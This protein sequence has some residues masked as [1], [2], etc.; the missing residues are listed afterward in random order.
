MTA[1]EGRAG[2]A[3]RFT[4]RCPV[5]PVTRLL[6]R[7]PPRARLVAAVVCLLA[8]AAGLI[9]PSGLLAARGYLARQAE[10]QAR[11]Y[12]RFLASRPF[13]VT[14]VFRFSPGGFA[15]RGPGGDL[16]RIEV[17][18]PDGRPV[19]STGPGR[20]PAL[21][22]A[23]TD[24]GGGSRA[25]AGSK[26][27]GGSWLVIA[28]PVRWRARRIPFD[29]DASAFAVRVTGRA[30][31]QPGQAGTLLVGLDLTRAESGLGTLTRVVLAVCAAVI[32]AAGFLT[33]AASRAVLARAARLAGPAPGRAAAGPAEQ[34]ARRLAG[35]AGDAG[36]P[37]SV[38]RGSAEYYRQQRPLGAREAGRLLQ[39]VAEEAARLDAII[40]GLAAAARPDPPGPHQPPDQ[41][42]PPRQHQPAQHQPPVQDLP[43]AQRDR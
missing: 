28:E 38:I 16:Y 37:L 22:R 26:A 19:V 7:V 9:V 13:T 42:R 12:V 31:H 5:R 8:A 24:P 4:G 29:Y 11:A 3:A 43:P 34:L 33:A 40:D 10:Q 27:R 39:R 20:W 41:A 18:G 25:R 30:L 36:R 14:P 1:D 23:V 17:L 21:P 6:R 32:L 2:R 15:P 35:I